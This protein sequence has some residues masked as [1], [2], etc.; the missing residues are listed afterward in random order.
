MTSN[1]DTQHPDNKSQSKMR[2]ACSAMVTLIELR[3][4]ALWGS[5]KDTGISNAEWTACIS[6]GKISVE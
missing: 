5:C 1:G 4:K 3:E 6:C 2:Q